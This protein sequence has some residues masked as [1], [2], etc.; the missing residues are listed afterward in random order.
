MGPKK[1]TMKEKGGASSVWEIEGGV[2][3]TKVGKRQAGFT[4]ALFYFHC[5][6]KVT[7]ALLDCKMYDNREG[8]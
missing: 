4:T 1:R 2:V 6:A 5:S 8:I 3:W 7:M